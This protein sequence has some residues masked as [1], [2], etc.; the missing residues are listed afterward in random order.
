MRRKRDSC[1]A[2]D[3]SNV[4]M[5]CVILF[6]YAFLF[7]RLAKKSWFGNFINLEKEEQ[8]FV[9]IRDKPLSSI[10]ADIVHAF[11]SVSLQWVCE[12][13]HHLL[14]LIS[15]QT[16]LTFLTIVRL[17]S[18]KNDA[19]TPSNDQKCQTCVLYSKSF[20]GKG[21]LCVTTDPYW[22]YSLIIFCSSGLLSSAN[23][24]NHSDQFCDL[25]QLI[26]WKD[27]TQ[28]KES[29]TNLISFNSWTRERELGWMSRFSVNNKFL[30]LTQ[31]IW[32]QKT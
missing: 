1:T 19:K 2:C 21:L 26:D 7:H 25:Y 29:L 14:T 4:C 27:L 8:I 32:L 3:L 16:C 13:C 18:F 5:Y 15:F 24:T 11:L 30:S 6:N 12:F 17:L 9:V 20:K 22:S 28:N 23:W 31:I 10:K